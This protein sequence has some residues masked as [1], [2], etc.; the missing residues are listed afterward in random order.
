MN[1]LVTIK[2]NALSP[3]HISTL[4]FINFVGHPVKTFKPDSYI[5]S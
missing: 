3:T 1:N 2:R 5:L 4:M